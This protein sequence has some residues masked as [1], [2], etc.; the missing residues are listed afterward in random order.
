MGYPQKSIL[1]AHIKETV[2]QLALAIPLGSL[3]GYLLLENIRG[4]FSSNSFV[5]SAVI[6]PQSYLIAALSV[7]VVTAIMAIVTSRHIERLD[8]VEGLKSQD[9]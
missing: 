9:D 3:L 5:I 2:G 7:I 6:F 8:I 4:E 1:M